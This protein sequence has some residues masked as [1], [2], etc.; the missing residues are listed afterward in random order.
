MYFYFLNYPYWENWRYGKEGEAIRAEAERR[1]RA[2]C[3]EWYNGPVYFY[4]A[5]PHVSVAAIVAA[6]HPRSQRLRLRRYVQRMILPFLF[7]AA[8][9]ASWATFQGRGLDVDLTLTGLFFSVLLALAGVLIAWQSWRWEKL[10]MD[11]SNLPINIRMMVEMYRPGFDF[12]QSRTSQTIL[13][14]WSIVV[15]AVQQALTEQIGL[16]VAGLAA[17]GAMKELKS[18]PVVRFDEEAHFREASP[19]EATGLL[20]ESLGLEDCWVD[21]FLALLH[22]DLVV[23][24][25]YREIGGAWGRL[26]RTENGLELQL[27]KHLSQP[28]R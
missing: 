9:G 2:Q 3:P 24:A 20:L 28:K 7:F 22:E 12:W 14:Q 23:A 19:Q 18:V 10:S 11:I 15:F 1:A 27:E 5:S 25:E 16:W 4:E 6:L 13:G 26:V 8:S 21:E 17:D